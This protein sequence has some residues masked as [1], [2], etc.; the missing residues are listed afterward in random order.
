METFHNI[1]LKNLDSFL[2]A[3]SELT[4]DFDLE[5]K[6]NNI[7]PK[8]VDIMRSSLIRS[9]EEM[10]SE[11]RAR[12]KEF[13]HQNN[14]KWGDGFD[15]LEA[16]IVICTE[17]GAEFNSSYRPK[18]VLDDNL[19]FE[20][21]VR[22]HARA[23]QISQE[24]LC[25]LK[26]GFADA[27]HARW[28]ALHEVNVTAMFISKHGQ[29]CAE[30][31]YLHDVV[32]SYHGMVEHKKYEHRL[33]A[34]GPKNEDVDKCKEH[35][36]LLIKKYGKKFADNYGWASYIFPNHNKLGFG[37]IE[38]DVQLEHMRPYYKWASQ[39]IHAGAK[40]MRNR[41]GLSHSSDDILLVGSSDAG[42]TDPA[43]ATAISLMQ[44]TTTLLSLEPTLDHIVVTKIIQEY[45][46]DIGAA[47][48]KVDKSFE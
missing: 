31:F 3:Q 46:D 10:L 35:F 41:L 21:V 25:L 2:E 15:L 24:I 13:F 42:M 1:F 32:D 20:I 28:R 48:V 36:N 43:H 6:I 5:G 45:T 29:E 18:A 27:A 40:G 16:M 8:I 44:I 39:N 23:C 17:S 33:Q 4:G 38:K 30:R 14:V 22:H 9:T 37:A 26:H 12:S 11:N 7:I 47:F 19:V 34:K